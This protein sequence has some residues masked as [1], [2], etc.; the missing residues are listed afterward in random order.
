MRASTE[1]GAYEQSVHLVFPTKSVLKFVGSKP[2]SSDYSV[3]QRL[4]RTARHHSGG[5]FALNAH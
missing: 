1:S 4:T 5:S 3:S 2:V